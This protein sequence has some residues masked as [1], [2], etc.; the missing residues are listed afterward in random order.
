MT[1]FLPISILAYALTGGS[2]LINKIQLQTKQLDP[3]SYTFYAGVLQV[4]ALFLVP[5][6]F[7]LNMSAWAIILAIFSGVAWL[8][9]L[10]A[11]F[12]ALSLVEASVVVPLVGGLNPLVSFLIGILV[13]GEIFTSLQLWAFLLFLTGGLTLTLNMWL[14]KLAL[15]TSFLWIVA[16]GFLFA[17][18]YVFLRQTFLQTTFINGLIISRVSAGI[19]SLFFLLMMPR[20][21]MS[22]SLRS[23]SVMVIFLAGQLLG[24]SASF[25]L[26]F[27]TSL[28]SPALVNA[29]FGTQYLVIIGAAFILKKQHPQLM[30][31]NLSRVVLVQK[32]AG[33]AI[34]SYGIYLLSR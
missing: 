14:K 21:A 20:Q 29:L 3:L 7:N 26:F 12:K 10:F 27:A 1:G 6:G 31:E 16:S 15:N 30:D 19:F 11:L 5:F 9:A 22:H 33:V 32:L 17:L 4:L 8:L 34:L 2:I 25:L 13:L 28:A 24:V 18:S 23:L